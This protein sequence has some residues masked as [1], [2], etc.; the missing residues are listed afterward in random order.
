METT[1]FGRQS[2]IEPSLAIT[3]LFAAGGGISPYDGGVT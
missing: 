1:L 3:G 2:R